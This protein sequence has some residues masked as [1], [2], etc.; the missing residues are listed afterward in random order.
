MIKAYTTSKLITHPAATHNLLSVELP[1]RAL[2][3]L[4]SN[5]LRQS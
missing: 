3:M 4:V 1:V 2:M 5:T